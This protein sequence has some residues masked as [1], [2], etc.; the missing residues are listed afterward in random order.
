[1]I[2]RLHALKA[3]GHRTVLT[4]D[5]RRVSRRCPCCHEAGWRAQFA[6][7]ANLDEREIKRLANLYRN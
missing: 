3:G 2:D 5:A 4:E 7:P 6:W 1:V